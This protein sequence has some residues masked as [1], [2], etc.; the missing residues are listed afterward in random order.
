MSSSS[1]VPDEYVREKQRRKRE[2][3]SSRVGLGVLVSLLACCC[4]IVLIAVPIVIVNANAADD[5]DDDTISCNCTGDVNPITFRVQS[6]EETDCSQV[7][8]DATMEVTYIIE[9]NNSFDEKCSPKTILFTISTRQG[10]P[11]LPIVGFTSSLCTQVTDNTLSC[12]YTSASNSKNTLTVVIYVS[13]VTLSDVSVYLFSTTN[14]TPACT[15]GTK[16][17]RVTPSCSQSS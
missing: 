11:I 16:E 3:A 7:D 14:T 1:Y 12:V 10:M 8:N 13:P 17:S 5:D 6:I 9:H 4:L 15:T 2:A